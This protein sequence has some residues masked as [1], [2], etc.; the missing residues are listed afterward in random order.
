[1]TSPIE[2]SEAMRS[3]LSPP[4]HGRPKAATKAALIV[5]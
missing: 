3:S 1:M 5:S 2:A 4:S